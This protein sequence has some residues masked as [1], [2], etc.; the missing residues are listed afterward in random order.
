MK[1]KLLEDSIVT[2]MT[3]F[4]NIIITTANTIKYYNN[5]NISNMSNI[6]YHNSIILN[7]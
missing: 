5:N 6:D 3:F 4:Q 1:Y 2:V 7:N